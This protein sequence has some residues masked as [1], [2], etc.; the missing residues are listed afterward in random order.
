MGLLLPNKGFFLTSTDH[1]PSSLYI[2]TIA[3]TRKPADFGVRNI[4]SPEKEDEQDTLSRYKETMPFWPV[5]PCRSFVLGPLTTLT[6]LQI[7][8]LSLC[9]RV[10]VVNYARQTQVLFFVDIVKK[11]YGKWRSTR[12]MRLFYRFSSAESSKSRLG[13][14]V[15]FIANILAVF[16]NNPFRTSGCFRDTPEMTQTY[17]SIVYE[18]FND[19]SLCTNIS[20]SCV[21]GIFGRKETDHAVTENRYKCSSVAYIMS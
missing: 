15:E 14:I 6:L 20:F 16:S 10:N 5:G 12:I 18:H 4:V 7:F 11:N 17:V 3:G 9:T 13:E 1:I 2:V 21:S 19:R 8:S